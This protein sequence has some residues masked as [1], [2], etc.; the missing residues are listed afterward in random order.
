[1]LITTEGP[2]SRKKHKHNTELSMEKKMVAQVSHEQ[3]SAWRVDTENFV[4]AESRMGIK[5]VKI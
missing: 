1:M 2:F 5:H 4:P 3:H